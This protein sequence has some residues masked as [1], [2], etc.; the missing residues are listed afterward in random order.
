[1][2]RMG[3]R[4]GRQGEGGDT[5]MR[6]R[7]PER[8]RVEVSASGSMSR[9]RETGSETTGAPRRMSM[10]LARLDTPAGVALPYPRTLV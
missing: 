5:V 3:T 7:N 6:R 2:V 8:G 1:M 9:R 4:T 10:M